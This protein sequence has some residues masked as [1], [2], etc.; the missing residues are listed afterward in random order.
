MSYLTASSTATNRYV[1]C[2]RQSQ[3]FFVFVDKTDTVFYVKERI[4]A[5]LSGEVSPRKMRLFLTEKGSDP[6]PDSATMADHEVSNDG[7]LYV[8]LRKNGMEDNDDDDDCWEELEVVNPDK[9]GD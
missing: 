6:L 1:R 3:T 9:M 8:V 7:C 4:S 5:A 2:K